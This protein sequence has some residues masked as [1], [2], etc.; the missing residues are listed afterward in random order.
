MKSN[1]AFPE[2]SAGGELGEKLVSAYN[3]AIKVLERSIRESGGQ[4][5]IVAGG[6]YPQVWTR[7]ASYN[8]LMAG[9]LLCPHISENTLKM[10]LLTFPVPM[11]SGKT[12]PGDPDKYDQY[13]DKMLW[14]VAAYENYLVTGNRDFIKVAYEASLNT[15][16]AILR[17]HLDKEFGLIKGPAF[18][19]DGIGS[20]PADICN[21][22]RIEPGKSN[23]MDYEE[24]HQIMTLS[25]NCIFVIALKSI[26]RM[27]NI[28]SDKRA[29]SFGKIAADISDS[30]NKYLWNEKRGNYDFFL[31]GYGDKR[32]TTAEY[33]ESAGQGFAIISGVADSERMQKVA[34]NIHSERYGTPLSW[35]SLENNY[36]GGARFSSSATG[37]DIP[38]NVTIWPNINGI[39]ARAFIEAGRYDRFV[40]ELRALTDLINT[41]EGTIYEIYHAKEGSPGLRFYPHKNPDQTWS[42]TA[43]I[44]MILYGIFGIKITENGIAHK[45]INLDGV[46]NAKLSRIDA[47]EIPQIR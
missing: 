36:I 45:T 11:I 31:Y 27:G 1:I 37:Y 5:V 15:A 44:N 8:T 33:Q 42:A 26:I 38:Q 3:T 35:P 19:C 21:E 29:D 40:Y 23:V 20:L 16:H 22:K 13:W 10:Q 25:A 2:F 4:R 7:D 30:I 24:P 28:L 6:S 18:M 9:N 46:K 43:Y 14:S 12:N 17:D 41:S 34:E 39:V 47:F 32:G